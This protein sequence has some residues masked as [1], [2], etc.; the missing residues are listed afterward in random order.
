MNQLHGKQIRNQSIANTKLAE[1]YLNLDPSK[2]QFVMGNG[3]AAGT[4]G[5]AI[6]TVN[7]VNDTILDVL[8]NA[9]NGI[10]YDVASK[11]LKLGG[12][13]TED[14]LIGGFGTNGLSLVDLKNVTI[15]SQNAN[16][17]VSIASQR[18]NTTVTA[19][20]TDKFTVTTQ[21][22]L[23]GESY[24]IEQNFNNDSLL[25]EADGAGYASVR[26]NGAASDV[27]VDAAGSVKYLADY[28][29][30]YT[31]R[32]LV[33]K[34]Y[35][36]DKVAS[37]TFAVAD[38][39]G[40]E[41]VNYGTAGAINLGGPI[42]QNTIID[43]SDLY[44]IQFNNMTSL[45][46]DATATSIQSGSFLSTSTVNTQIS[47]L[48]TVGVNLRGATPGN[49]ER[50]KLQISETVAAFTDSRAV[51]TGLVYAADYS[52]TFTDLSLVN[53]KYVDTVAQGLTPLQ[54]VRVA[55][56]SDIGAIYTTSPNNGQF[57]S[58]PTTI[59]GVLLSN[60]DRILVKDQADAKQNGVYFVVS[61]GTWRRS[62]DL[63]GSPEI[64]VNAGDY[65]FV[66]QG[67]ANSNTG[68]V[69]TA[70]A[71]STSGSA[72]ILTLNVN[73]LVWVKFTEIS[74]AGSDT[75]VQ[76]ND[77]GVQ[78]AVNAFRFNKV[79]GMLFTPSMTLTT[80][81]ASTAGYDI[82]VRNITTGKL[83]IVGATGLSGSVPTKSNKNMQPASA[84]TSGNGV[85]TLLTIAGTPASDSYVQVE[86]NG[87]GVVLGTSSANGDCYFAAPGTGG[88][89]GRTIANI[90]AN[91]E[92]FWNGANAGFALD[93][94]D[95]VDFLY[96]IAS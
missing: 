47:G 89:V 18:A 14:T 52:A 35:V 33:D 74:V 2:N 67:T 66:E 5:N 9:S 76:F 71:A 11:T 49:I 3:Y 19:L 88:S 95:R 50:T 4:N 80:P 42:T 86:I 96:N 87:M 13:L 70:D 83:E 34:K 91:D 72:N 37:G 16:A 25:I 55:T 27:V 77:G 53:K 28:R 43:G 30:N 24:K 21:N 93:T 12:P 58:A 31:D 69:L 57:S 1:Q 73:P 36:D 61:S 68:W 94:L 63:D 59:D 17:T 38:G 22:T 23:S 81:S 29:N 6:A 79:Q 45:Q 8:D 10:R 65:V 7:I 32:S 62:S 41:V 51:P 78:G 26:V 39:S 46:V 92:F 75:E 56:T 64:E 20:M 48:G 40:V 85:P 54:A 60:N 84:G 44:N 15:Q 82:V 90:Q